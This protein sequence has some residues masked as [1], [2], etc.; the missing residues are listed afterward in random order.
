[1]SCS[2][3]PIARNRGL[4]RSDK[5]TSQ[6]TACLMG[7]QSPRVQSQGR[8]H[9]KTIGERT[10]QRLLY[11]LRN[12][13]TLQCTLANQTQCTPGTTLPHLLSHGQGLFHSLIG[14][15]LIKC[16]LNGFL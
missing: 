5:L 4:I 13:A 16:P 6:I 12:T 10:G 2:S 14:F 11:L 15:P 3:L 9:H 7:R 8:I 1:M